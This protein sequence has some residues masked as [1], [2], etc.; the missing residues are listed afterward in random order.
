MTR[1]LYDR[2]DA[3]E[4]FAADVAHELKNP[5]TSLK[6]AVEMFSRAGDDDGAQAAAGDR[7]Q[8]RQAHRPA[9]H[10]HFRRLASRCRTL[11]R[12]R[13]NRWTWCACSK[14]SSRSTVSPILP[15]GVTLDAPPPICPPVS[16]MGRDERFGQIVRNLVD[17]AVSFSPEGGMVTISAPSRNRAC[18]H[19][20]RRPRPRHP[21]GESRIHLRSLLYGTPG[22]TRLRQ[23][24]RPRPLHRRQIAEG[25]ADASGRKTAAEAAARASP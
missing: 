16:V 21:A 25:S 7:P 17:N 6:S 4:S 2:I 12:G 8:R 18:A 9:D 10:R 22:R 14:P 11:A 24:F 3:I 1:A 5:L 23:E 19:R 20:G 13:A 15:R